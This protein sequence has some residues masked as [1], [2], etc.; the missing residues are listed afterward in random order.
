MTRVVVT[1]AGSGF[2]AAIVRSLLARGTSVAAC[3]A[4]EHGVRQVVDPE[5]AAG[6]RLSV[7]AVPLQDPGRIA[8]ACAAIAASG[9]VDA[10]VHNAGYAV[11]NAL[12]DACPDAVAALFDAN[13]LGTVRVMRG[14]V[15]AVRASRGTVVVVSSVAGRMVFPES[16]FYAAAKHALEALAEG[17]YAELASQ[18]VRVAVIE[19][20][21]FA[22]GFGARAA[23]SS[24]GR[25]QP[26]PRHGIWD[27][28]K[29]EVL[30]PPQD[31]ARVAMAVLDALDGGP[32]FQRIVVGCDAARILTLRDTL[33]ADGFVRLMGERMGGPAA[34]EVARP[35]AVCDAGGDAF[36]DGPLAG[37]LAA[38][39][40]GFLGHWADS[41][42]G[43]AALGRLGRLADPAGR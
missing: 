16:G 4:T 14:L 6:D 1:G 43:R 18:G 30:A 38:Y 12:E 21:A 23:A 27:A 40:A 8:T 3:D 5:G 9:P 19:P 7:H 17:W 36:V 29:A 13:V 31:P 2:G 28:R 20:G 24:R 10:V 33:G 42:T 39:Q 25:A 32:A 11:F 35:E 34:P 15:D 26:E 37:A 41:P 22:T